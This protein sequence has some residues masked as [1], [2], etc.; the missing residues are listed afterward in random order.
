MKLALSGKSGAPVKKAALHNALRDMSKGSR[1]YFKGRFI[2][3]IESGNLAGGEVQWDKVWKQIADNDISDTLFGKENKEAFGR[4]ATMI[5]N[6]KGHKLEGEKAEGIAATIGRLIFNATTAK[7]LTGYLARA[8]FLPTFAGIRIA[9]DTMQGL[10]HSGQGY[11][12]LRT[13]KQLGRILARNMTENPDDFVKAVLM[14]EKGEPHEIIRWFHRAVKPFTG[15]AALPYWAE[16]AD[17]EIEKR[18]EKK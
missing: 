15:A 12:A 16:V 8:R 14:N 2:D 10:I 11:K 1:N 17:E 5:K 9:V 18:T 3:A 4:L 7:A 6:V 13:N